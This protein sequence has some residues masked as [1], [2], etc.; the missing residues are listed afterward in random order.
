MFDIIFRRIVIQCVDNLGKLTDVI[1]YAVVPFQNS[2][3]CVLPSSGVRTPESNL[4]T[5]Y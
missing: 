2:R 5:W 4:R 3:T 1:K